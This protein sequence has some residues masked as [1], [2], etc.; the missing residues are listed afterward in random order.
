MTVLVGYNGSEES[1]K[2]LKLAQKHAKAFAT[3]VEVVTS[4]T[5]EEPLQYYD[6]EE[7]EQKL[8]SD[9]NEVLDNR[10]VPIE[11]H[12]VVSDRGPGE[13]LVQYA[14]RIDA[15]EIIIGVKKILG[16][17]EILH[18]SSARFVVFNATCPVVTVN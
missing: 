18:S 17:W 8:K 6:I 4:I 14:E 13:Q 7:A 15:D 12:L 11:T 5:R 9:V 16:V 10:S 1:K 2:A 3:N